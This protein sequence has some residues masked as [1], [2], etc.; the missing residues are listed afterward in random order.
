MLK[1]EFDIISDE[2]NPFYAAYQVS[3]TDKL[4]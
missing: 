1:G 4:S 2:E 3:K